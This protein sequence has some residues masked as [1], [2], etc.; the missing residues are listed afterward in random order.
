MPWPNPSD[1]AVLIIDGTEYRDWETILVRHALMDVPHYYCR[2]TCSEAIG[3]GMT[4]NWAA[5]RIVP[6]Q[7]CTVTLGGILAFTGKVTTRQ[8][9]YDANRHHVE[10]QCA[11]Y[12]DIFTGSVIHNT[13]EWP[14]GTT[15]RQ[16]MEDV[17]RPYNI[18]LSVEGGALPSTPLPITRANLGETVHD[19]LDHL[20]RSF[21]TSAFGIAFTSNTSGDFVVVVGP[22]S[23]MDAVVEGINIL[24]GREIIQDTH[25]G[26]DVPHAGQ[27]VPDNQEWGAQVTHMPWV[28]SAMQAM[29]GGKKPGAAIGIAEMP[30]FAMS[31]LPLLRGRGFSETNWLTNDY[32]TVFATVRGWMRPSGGLWFRSQLVSVTSPMLLMNGT[33]LTLKNATFTQDNTSGTRT[34]LEIVNSMAMG[35]GV[36]MAEG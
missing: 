13:M 30:S 27:G 5:M 8:V 34:T 32:V 36:P 21:S 22:N 15:L 18:R 4:P 35:G 14:K 17:L 29:V 11:V 24:E 28:Q 3:S 10:I 26:L 19:F 6:G 23:A 7:S 33:V 2:F 9:F 16:I 20:A 31:N 25:M 1:V 12:E